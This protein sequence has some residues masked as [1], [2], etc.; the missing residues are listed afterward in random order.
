MGLRPYPHLLRKGGAGSG[1]AKPVPR[2]PLG[3]A[4]WGRAADEAGFGRVGP[5]ASEEG[6]PRAAGQSPFRYL[7][8][9]HASDELARARKATRSARSRR[10]STPAYPIA[11]PGIAFIG[12]ARK[13]SSVATVQTTSAF[14]MASE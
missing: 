12:F 11:V 2:R 3:V 10:S 5:N 14:L 6:A 1:R 7:P 4:R 9:A 8:L 13:R